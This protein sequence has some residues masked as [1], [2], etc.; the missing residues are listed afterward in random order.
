MADAKGGEELLGA[1]VVGE[2]SR[3]APVIR[4]ITVDDITSALREGADDFRAMPAFGMA[5]GLLYALGGMALVYF[6]WNVPG[7]E[8]LAFPLLGGFALVGPFAAMGLY[9]ASR[10]RDLGQSVGLGDLFS[11]RAATTTPNIFFLGF[12]LLFAL[13]VWLRVA[14]LIYALFFGISSSGSLGD[15]VVDVFTTANGFAFLVIGNAVG[16]AFAF[17]VFAISVVSF[18]YML[19]KDVDPVS[20]VALSVSAVAKNPLPLAGWALFVAVALAV[21]WA[22]FFLGLIVVLPVLGHATWRLYKKMIV[23]PAG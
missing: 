10:R 2:L 7:Y 19:E 15:L 11:V 18:P 5:I 14:L 13:F 4:E 6:A 17:V 8:A 23:H 3:N 16:A 22:P 20:A 12:I 21:S 1:R 9:E